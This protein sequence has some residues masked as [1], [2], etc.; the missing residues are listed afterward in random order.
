MFD[1]LSSGKHTRHFDLT[2]S[3]LLALSSFGLPIYRIPTDNI[4]LLLFV[5]VPQIVLISFHVST[6]LHTA[7]L[8]A[9]IL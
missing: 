5:L 2:F 6:A 1:Y 3:S 9:N 8:A 7:L 4:F